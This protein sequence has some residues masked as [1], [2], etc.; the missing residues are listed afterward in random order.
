MAMPKLNRIVCFILVIM[1]VF[2]IFSLLPFHSPDTSSQ[3]INEDIGS[4]VQSSQDIE[5]LDIALRANSPPRSY[6]LSAAKVKELPLTKI[7]NVVIDSAHNTRAPPPNPRA[8]I[9]V[10]IEEVGYHGRIKELG[11]YAAGE[12]GEETEIYL[13]VKNYGTNPVSNIKIDWKMSDFFNIVTD[14]ATKNIAALDPDENT[15]VSFIWTPTYAN[16][17][18][19]TFDVTVNGDENLSNNNYLWGYIAAAKWTDDFEDGDLNGW[20]GDLSKNDLSPYKWHVTDTVQSDPNSSKHSS[21]NALYHGKEDEIGE[22]DNYGSDE[23]Y[24]ITT[25]E[26]DLRRF[27]SSYKAFLLYLFY[28]SSTLDKDELTVEVRKAPGEEFTVIDYVAP[29]SGPTKDSTSNKLAW[30]AHDTGTSNGTLPGIPINLYVGEIVQFRLHWSSDLAFEEKTGF[31]FDD[32]IV[33]GIETPPPEK[34][35]AVEELGSPT[36]ENNVWDMGVVGEQLNI[37]A[38]IKN[39]GSTPAGPF[40]VK[41]KITDIT[42]RE[43]D[44]IDSKIKQISILNPN[45]VQDL[46]WAFIPTVSGIYYVNVSTNLEGDEAPENSYDDTLSFKVAKYYFDG[47]DL[48]PQDGSEQ[49]WGTAPE[50][51][52][53]LTTVRYDPSPQEHTSSKAWYFGSPY[54]TYNA[55]LNISLY[56]PVIDLEGVEIDPDY[57]F[58]QIH[59]NFKWY[60]STS[61]GDILFFEYALDEDD[62]WKLVH[63]INAGNLENSTISGNF[64]NDWHSWYEDMGSNEFAGHHVQFRLRFQSDEI[65]DSDKIGFYI[66]DF[67]VWVLKE[68]YGRP[69]IHQISA[70]PSTVLND[71]L[72]TTTLQVNVTNTDIG[73]GVTIE[74][75]TVNLSLIGGSSLQELYD[76]GNFELGDE[77]MGDGIYSVI[78][79]VNTTTVP[80]AKKLTVTA[81]ASN[82]RRDIAYLFLQVRANQPPEILEYM[83]LEFEVTMHENEMLAFSAIVQD[84]DRDDGTL[85]YNWFLNDARVLDGNNESIFNFTTSYEGSHSSGIYV[86]NLTVY[87]DGHPSLSDSIEWIINVENVAAD[88]TIRESDIVFS[89]AQI[90]ENETI[91]INGTIHNFGLPPEKNI[92][93]LFFQQSNIAHAPEILISNVTIP[94][95]D[96][97]GSVNIT[98]PWIADIS[99]DW[100]KIKIDPTDQIIEFN[101]SN[102]EAFKQIEVAAKP[103][104]PPPPEVPGPD[105]NDTPANNFILNFNIIVTS[106]SITLIVLLSFIVAGT[107]FGTYKVVSMFIPLYS[108]V[109]GRKILDHTLRQRIYNEIKMHP[110]IHYRFIMTKLK[111]KNGTLVHHLMRLEQEELIKSERDGVYKRFYPIGLRIPK[112]EVSQYFPD[113]TKTF[114]IGTHQVSELQMNVIDIIR[115]RPGLTQKEISNRINESRRV[116]NYHIKLLIQH[117]IIYLEK[118]GRETKCYILDEVS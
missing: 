41:I 63:S 5:D 79:P 16:L 7:S 12:V 56:S 77:V 49:D 97:N 105:G 67:V 101:E 76:D 26:L 9:D 118:V 11:W 22:G 117:N 102:N 62:D 95:L 93:V 18:N 4:K 21:P 66:D 78:T 113:G 58:Y 34:D 64:I 46:Y 106:V 15:S 80:G 33:Y 8:N 85:R 73:A 108:R 3:Q 39:R 61:S 112:S 110:G 115:E 36:V 28:G 13:V 68:E 116:V 14:S 43:V 103:P 91:F 19:I 92:T 109:S 84:P 100:I 17:Y 75:V 83:P 94:F 71:G 96:G 89:Q 99:A 69:R 6:D 48:E 53:Y 1:L 57:Q 45:E 70:E 74:S 38:N 55:N 59:T 54:R 90:I 37:N 27:N 60:G 51:S 20:T 30:W 31:Y 86:L 81:I 104:L 24:V 40:N 82:A 72:E 87:D 107:E 32:F 47:L 98:I 50:N 2:T 44:T 111:L 65:S 35:I 42:N 25:P 88:L 114:N 23:D 29:L 10:G 52:W